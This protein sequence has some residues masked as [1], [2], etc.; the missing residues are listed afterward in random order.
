MELTSQETQLK[1]SLKQLE[2][3]Y[4]NEIQLSLGEEFKSGNLKESKE[5]KNKKKNDLKEIINVAMKKQ[6]AEEKEYS[7]QKKINEKIELDIKHLQN[8]ITKKKSVIKNASNQNQELG[9]NINQLD[10]QID[11]FSK[12]TDSNRN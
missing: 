7:N 4:V 8:L 9:H 3:I 2:T 10:D 12:K 1:N 11:I 6:I 5:I